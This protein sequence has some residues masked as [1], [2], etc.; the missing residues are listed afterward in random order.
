M[1]YR[2]LSWPSWWGF[3]PWPF[4]SANR[5]RIY[6]NADL[7]CRRINGVWLRMFWTSSTLHQ[8]SG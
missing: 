6:D 7:I 2:R 4:R 1:K 3:R 8:M 5:S